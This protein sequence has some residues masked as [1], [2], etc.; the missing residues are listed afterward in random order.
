MFPFYFSCGCNISFLI[1]LWLYLSI[2]HEVKSKLMPENIEIA[3][4]DG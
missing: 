2:I 4:E 3:K 1:F